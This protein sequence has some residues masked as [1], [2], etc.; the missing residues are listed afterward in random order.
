MPDVE[1][2]TK[3]IEGYTEKYFTN[4]EK[5][6]ETKNVFSI[7]STFNEHFICYLSKART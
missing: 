6:M 3:S 7:G 2:I 1:K 4:Q 5:V